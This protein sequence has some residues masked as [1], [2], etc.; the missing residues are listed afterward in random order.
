MSKDLSGVKKKVDISMDE[1]V[2]LHDEVMLEEFRIMKEVAHEYG[3]SFWTL[4]KFAAWEEANPDWEKFAKA[5]LAIEERIKQN[6]LYRTYKEIKEQL[7]K[8]GIEV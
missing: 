6:S 8:Q 3:V 1:F 2:K 4:V 5:L 7:K